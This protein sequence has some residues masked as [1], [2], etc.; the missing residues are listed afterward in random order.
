MQA[1]IIAIGSELTS[2]AKLDTN[3]QWL[4]HQ[5]ASV[6]VHVHFHSTVADSVENLVTLMKS[7]VDRSDLV[8]ITGG[9]GPTLDDLTRDAMA[10]LIDVELE[11]DQASL[12]HLEAMFVKRGRT[13]PRRNRIQ[14]MFP[15]GSRP[16]ENHRGTAPG[17]RME[18]PR[19]GT[20]ACILA[21]FPGVPSEMKPMFI[22]SIMSDLTG[23]GRVIRH[24]RINCFGS[25][26]SHIEELLGDLTARGNDPEVGITAHDATITMRIM[27]TGSSVAECE[28]KIEDA[29]RTVYERLG[30]LVFGEEDVE[31]QHV[32]VNQLSAAGKTVCCVEDATT[33][34]LAQW[35]ASVD[36]ADKVFLGGLVVSASRMTAVLDATG[37]D[38]IRDIARNC[39]AMFG[40]DYA[41]AIGPLTSSTGSEIPEIAFSI[42][43]EDLDFETSLPLTG[44]PA[45]MKS[46]T[47]KAAVNALRQHLKRGEG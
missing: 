23:T 19:D 36:D 6:G 2:G 41:I 13:M 27:A 33:G 17:I 12:D 21:A 37:S 10:R 32:L 5:L 3:S 31:L 44:N 7:A 28:T 38:R 18:V 45:I 34:Q 20:S 22:D 11:F 1:E 25:G 29:R 30:D 24:A 8:L 40:S 14:A 47:A 26:E 4:S 43:G 35:I 39:R 9:L 15:K 42:V 46:R 16:I